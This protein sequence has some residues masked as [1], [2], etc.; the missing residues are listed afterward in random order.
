MEIQVNAIDID[1]VSFIFC[2]LLQILEPCQ[3]NLAYQPPNTWTMGI[4][5]LLVEIHAMP[6]FRKNLAFDF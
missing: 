5:G 6:N 4:L 3:S 2:Y 1:G